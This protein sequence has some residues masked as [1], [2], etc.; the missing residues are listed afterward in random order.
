LKNEYHKPYFNTIN[1]IFKGDLGKE[2]VKSFIA[3]H[4]L[5]EKDLMKSLIQKIQSNNELK[6]SNFYEKIIY[7]INKEDLNFSGFSE[8]ETYGSYVAKFFPNKYVF[9]SIPSF[10][11][12]RQF[13]GLPN[14]K[15]L[16]WISKD[17]S[18]VSIEKNHTQGLGAYLSKLRVIRKIFTFS[19]FVLILKS[20]IV[21]FFDRLF[22][23]INNLFKK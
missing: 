19:K 16:S 15:Q 7:S 21:N 4:M 14:S 8:F 3:E 11:E 2:V 20:P 23:K 22:V 1:K 10:R 6:G 5:I 13:L 9:R 12:G 18:I 17:F